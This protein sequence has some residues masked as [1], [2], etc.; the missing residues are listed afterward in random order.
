MRVR[1]RETCGMTLAIDWCRLPHSESCPS[2]IILFSLQITMNG[3][4][5]VNLCFVCLPACLPPLL[6]YLGA[7]SLSVYKSLW[8]GCFFSDHAAQACDSNQLIG[9]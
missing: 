4:V 5:R 7:Q 6:L 1:V 3:G 8:S 9:Q 2:W